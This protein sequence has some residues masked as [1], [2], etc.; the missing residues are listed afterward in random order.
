M[1]GQAVGRDGLL[2]RSLKNSKTEL[3]TL[4]RTGSS[5]ATSYSNFTP[6]VTIASE[7]PEYILPYILYYQTS[8][9]VY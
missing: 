4:T 5:D 2:C 3:V 7:F 8:L 9:N 6:T 1:Q